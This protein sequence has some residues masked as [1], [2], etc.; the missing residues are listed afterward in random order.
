LA[1]TVAAT[2]ILPIEGLALIFGVYRFLSIAI[3]ACNVVGN[4]VATLIVAKL[5][6]EFDEA[7]AESNV[8]GN[9]LQAN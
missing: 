8:S 5:A 4:T 1:A 7:T 3:A 6:G 2:G 9:C